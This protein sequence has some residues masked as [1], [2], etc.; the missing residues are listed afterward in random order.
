MGAP[1]HPATNGQAERYVRTVK[2]KLLALRNI[3]KRTQH[4]TTGESPSMRLFQRQIRSRL[5]LIIPH[6]DKK[7]S[8]K[9]VDEKIHRS[10]KVNDRIAVRNYKEGEVKWKFGTIQ[11]KLGKL[12]YDVRLDNGK[13]WR[14]H[15]DQLRKVGEEVGKDCPEVSEEEYWNLNM[16][17]HLTSEVEES[18]VDSDEEEEFEDALEDNVGEENQAEQPVVFPALPAALPLRRSQRNIKAPDRLNL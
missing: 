10:F 2:E 7:E 17:D 15:V 16:N 12:H 3:N 13:L 5:D 11:E 14:R 9:Q 1:Y 18:K 6:D 8:T 4:S